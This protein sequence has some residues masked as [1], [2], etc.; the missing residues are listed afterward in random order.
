MNKRARLLAFEEGGC[1]TCGGK[2]SCPACIAYGCGCG[3]E[4]LGGGH[5]PEKRQKQQHTRLYY[6]ADHFNNETTP[7]EAKFDVVMDKAL[8]ERA[9]HYT[10]SIVRFVIPGGALPVRVYEP[11]T[12]YTRLNYTGPSGSFQQEQG[13]EFIMDSTLGLTTQNMFYIHNIQTIINIINVALLKAF[14]QLKR[15]HP[16]IEQT[17][18]P[19][20]LYDSGTGRFS[21]NAVTPSA[22]CG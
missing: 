16:A 17:T 19:F 1:A 14:V 8:L 6:D 21:L 5:A 15:D 12:W 9:D 11:A 18:P 13:T 2:L 3:P 4:F 7:K 22:R 10:L 20:M